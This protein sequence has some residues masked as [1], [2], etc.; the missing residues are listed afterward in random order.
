MNKEI[1]GYTTATTVLPKVD[2]GPDT[3]G[4]EYVD[5]G[6]PSGT[7]WATMNVGATSSTEYGDYYMYGM[8]AKTYDNTDTPYDGMEDP[9]DL[10]KDTARVVW[11]GEWHMPTRAQMQELIDN[12]TWEWVTINNTNGSKFTA[13]NG[14]F[15]FLPAA[16]EESGSANFVGYYW[17]SSPGE[18]SGAYSLY[19]KDVGVWNNSRAR[20][21][22]VRSV[23][24]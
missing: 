5:L 12:T 1:I 13:Q 7:L 8:G 2:S 3:N 21:F 15:V 19:F 11:G 9:L 17:S 24:G 14:N 18:N 22:S 4:H 23:I 16:G 10:T 20:G 6:L